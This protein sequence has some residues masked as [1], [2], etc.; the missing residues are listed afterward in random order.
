[1]WLSFLSVDAAD[2][3]GLDLEVTAGT[4]SGDPLQFFGFVPDGKEPFDYFVPFAEFTATGPV[5]L[6]EISSLTL[7]FN[8]DG[9]PNVDFELDAL[10][11]IVPEP[12]APAMLGLGLFLLVAAGRRRRKG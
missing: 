10:A 2:P 3:G 4:S 11:A 7:A 5:S 6:A 12:S 9:T 1:M 8:N